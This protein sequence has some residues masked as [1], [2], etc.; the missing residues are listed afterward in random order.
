MRKIPFKIL[1]D[2]IRKSKYYISYTSRCTAKKKKLHC[3]T[4][5]LMMRNLSDFG[6]CGGFVLE[7]L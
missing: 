2:K 5:F 1:K 6:C 7:D 3:G 4:P